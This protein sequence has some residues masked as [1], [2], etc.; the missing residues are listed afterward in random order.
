MKNWT[1]YV[2]LV[3]FC[4]VAQVR[5]DQD[6]IVDLKLAGTETSSG[7][8]KSEDISFDQS[9]GWAGD[10]WIGRLGYTDFGEMSYLGQSYGGL[11]LSVKGPYLEAAR[12]IDLSWRLQVELGGGVYHNTIDA[13]YY[14][15]D[16]GSTTGTDPFVSLTLTKELISLLSLQVGVKYVKDVGGTNL[17]LLSGGVRFSF[18]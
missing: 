11:Y 13:E 3:S 17:T 7:A 4:A 2:I 18:W 10:A 6:F 16:L 9:I 1:C 8:F 14:S 5:A 15:H 12:K